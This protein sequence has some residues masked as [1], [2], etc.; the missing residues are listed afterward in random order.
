VGNPA[1]L[2]PQRPP[3]HD[4]SKD[5]GISQTQGEELD[6]VST[7]L[8]RGELGSCGDHADSNEFG[9]HRG[10]TKKGRTNGCI[11]FWGTVADWVFPWQNR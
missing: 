7:G 8:I 11:F 6:L 4:L 10:R 5:R 1:R 3:I 9:A 2:L